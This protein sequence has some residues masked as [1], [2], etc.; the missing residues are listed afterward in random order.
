[1][2]HGPDSGFKSAFVLEESLK[3]GQTASR[4]RTKGMSDEIIVEAAHV[5]VVALFSVARM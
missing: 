1:M 2:Q 5:A 3:W 4:K